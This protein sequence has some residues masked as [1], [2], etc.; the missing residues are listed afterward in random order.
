MGNPW[1]QGFFAT[2]MEQYSEANVVNKAL[3]LGN[4]NQLGK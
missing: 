2:A 3:N 1:M 4:F